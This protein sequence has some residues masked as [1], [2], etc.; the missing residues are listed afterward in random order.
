MA[1]RTVSLDEKI[2][3]AEA[4]VTAAK[5][6]YDAAL[7]ELEKLL[8]RRKKLDEKKAR[9]AYH[10]G[11]KSVDETHKESSARRA[12]GGPV[13]KL[14]DEDGK[15]FYKLWLPLLDYVN[16]KKGICPDLHEIHLSAAL[17]P[18]K[19]KKV[20]DAL[21]SETSLIDAYLRENKD[22]AEEEKAIILSWKR[23]VTGR[24]ILERILK[25]GAILISVENDGEDVYQVLGIQSTWEELCGYAKLPLL[26][27][28]T[29]IPFRD[30]IIPDGLI[31]TYNVL[32]G[33]GMAQAFKDVYMR[34]KNNGTIHR[35]L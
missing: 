14:S 18:S 8:A 34:E 9:E 17:D 28:A 31:L 6:Q 16:E 11:D 35:Q 33:G 3:N 13:M 19:I 23:R 27:H 25:K 1:R 30:V 32:I 24:F 7:E 29:L 26:L 2:E 20:A 10:A 22:L 12:G 4:A 21:W 5:A 15:L